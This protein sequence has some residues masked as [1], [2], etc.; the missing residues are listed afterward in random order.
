MDP[1]D[2][3]LDDKPG[4]S[5][6]AEP[7]P[8]K[9]ATKPDSSPEPA[10]TLAD[11][12]KETAASHAESPAA[13]P[14]DKPADLVEE[15]APDKAEG[16]EPSDKPKLGDESLPFHKHPRFQELVKERND[17]K[18]KIEQADPALKRDA[19]LTKYCQDNGIS[20]DE[21]VQ[22]ME[23][24]ALL[25][26]D[27]AKALE[28]LRG[29]VETLEL[30]LGNK[31]PADLQK[32]VDDGALSEARA[33]ELANLRVKAQGLEFSGKKSEAQV[34]QERQ[35]ANVAAVNAWE[36]SKRST[37]TA[38]AKKAPLIQKAFVALCAMQPPR[39]AAE[40]VALAEQAYKEV[41]DALGTLTP[42]PP[43]RRVL[44]TNGATVKGAI[45][46]K[47]GTSLREAL[48]LIAKQ[49]A[50]QHRE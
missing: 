32:E 15:V 44:K 8:A 21:F 26:N 45:E 11:V 37:D 13:E 7:S 14:E 48:P 10:K 31:L 12:V 40:A 18:Q 29:Y 43:E 19:N 23:V 49:V 47:A 3:V 34:A 33:K 4:A 39:S 50:A 17:F 22:A 5:A 6:D 36:E 27:P 30:T 38:Y 16:G 25:H 24:A 2:N 9:D 1:E 42:K 20:N 28:T 46:V 35:Q 41:N